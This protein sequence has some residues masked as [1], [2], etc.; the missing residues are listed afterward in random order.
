MISHWISVNCCQRRFNPCQLSSNHKL[1]YQLVS[2][3]TN[4]IYHH[5]CQLFY[6]FDSMTSKPPGNIISIFI[7]LKFPN[8]NKAILM[9]RCVQSKSKYIYKRTKAKTKKEK[10][11]YG[12]RVWFR[13]GEQKFNILGHTRYTNIYSGTMYTLDAFI[14]YKMR[15]LLY[16][17]TLSHYSF[18][19]SSCCSLIIAWLKPTQTSDSIKVM[20]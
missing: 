13:S 18:F 5:R 14:F 19:F 15:G 10:Y 1:F 2:C 17:L 8:W 6:R 11:F 4:N 12:N 7:F 16:S 9:R 20:R 3:Y